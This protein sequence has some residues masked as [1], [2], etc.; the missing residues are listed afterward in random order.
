MISRAKFF[1]KSEYTMETVVINTKTYKKDKALMKSEE[2]SALVVIGLIALGAVIG[3]LVG[4]WKNG[5]IAMAAGGLIGY[6][7]NYFRI[8]RDVESHL[9]AI[10]YTS[11][12][13]YEEEDKN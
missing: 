10:E 12:E 2:H 13:T 9:E 5:L 8:P 3:I 4:F 6:I 1:M 11:E 7:V